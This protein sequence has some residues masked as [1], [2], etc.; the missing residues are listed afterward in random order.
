[1]CGGADLTS[2]RGVTTNHEGEKRVVYH[3]AVGP[4]DN[5]E[6]CHYQSRKGHGP[7]SLQKNEVYPVKKLKS[8]VLS[9][10]PCA[11]ILNN[12]F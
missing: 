11:G 8:Y 3:F 5:R 7:G 10:L 12:G 6:G 4:H 1:M 2:V 9:L